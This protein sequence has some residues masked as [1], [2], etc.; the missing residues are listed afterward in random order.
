MRAITVTA[1]WSV[2]YRDATY[3]RSEAVVANGT[4]MAIDDV[5]PRMTK[6]KLF[7]HW[8]AR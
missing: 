7:L 8:V 2:P 5:T 1:S 4:E 6:S 3:S